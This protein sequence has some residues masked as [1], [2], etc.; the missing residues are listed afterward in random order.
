MQVGVDLGEAGVGQQGPLAVGPPDRRGV[1][2][3]GVGGEKEHVAVAAGGQ[4]HRLGRV[5]LQRA[6]EQVAGHHAPGHPIHRDQLQQV[7]AGQQGDAP[8]RHL[9]QQGRCGA[10]EQLLAGLAAGVEGAAHQRPPEAAAGQGAAVLAGEGHALGHALI[11]DAAAQLGQAHAAGLAGAEVAAA[12][13]VGEQALGAVA[14]GGIVLGGVDAPLGGHRVGPPRAVVISEHRHP[15]A[16]LGEG[17]GGRGTGQAR[18]HHQHVQLA[19]AQRADQRQLSAGAAP[20]VGDRAGGQARIGQTGHQAPPPASASARVTA[21][22]PPPINT[23]SR[24]VAARMGAPLA[25]C[26]S[27]RLRWAASPPWNRCRASARPPA[28]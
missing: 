27:P 24:R 7:A 21:T 16:L 1:R 11:N 3:E 6:R 4:Q 13:G 19:L 2:L 5:H 8:G 14:I 22:K 10:V 26:N 17:G 25:G 18:A 28:R 9:A 12:Q 15:V 20:G 23:A